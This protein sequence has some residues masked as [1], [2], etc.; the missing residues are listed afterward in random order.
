MIYI[1]NFSSLKFPH[2]K[3][4]GSTSSS[5]HPKNGRVIWHLRLGRFTFFRSLFNSQ[6]LHITPA[7]DDIFV[8]DIRRRHDIVW[9]PTFSAKQDNLFKGNCRIF[10][11]DLMQST[12][13]TMAA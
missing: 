8:D 9:S 6:V 3:R 11:A 5:T 4:H 13:I 12:N 7:E 10:R 2:S 1:R